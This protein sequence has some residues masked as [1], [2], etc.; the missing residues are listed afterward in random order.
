[1]SDY[2]AV[3]FGAMQTA[4]G[5]F[6]ATYQALQSTLTS[7]EAQLQSSLSEW[8]GEAQTAYYAA[9]K[10]WDAAA[11]DMATVVSQLSQV[12]GVANENYMNAERA[13]TAMW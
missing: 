12:V 4:E 3:Q 5:D 6:A 9:K 7:L 8:T 11:A 2:T 10:K 1:M 13:N